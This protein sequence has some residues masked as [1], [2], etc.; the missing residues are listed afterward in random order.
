[1]ILAITTEGL[2]VCRNVREL[3]L[4][5]LERGPILSL[6]RW[7]ID[8]QLTPWY[9]RQHARQAERDGLVKL[10]RQWGTPGQP[11]LVELIPGAH[12]RL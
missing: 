10:Q 7:A 8:N 5:S 3:L 11:Y 2:I 6:D 9:V 4:R 12:D 1:M